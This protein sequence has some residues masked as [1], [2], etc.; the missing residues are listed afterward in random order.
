MQID[1]NPLAYFKELHL[2]PRAIFAIGGVFFFSGLVGRNVELI[3][4][5]IGLIFVA[6]A[7]NL[8]LNAF[9][10]HP[11]DGRLQFWWGG[12]AQAIP[13]ILVGL[14]CIYLAAYMYRHGSLPPYFQRA[15]P[16]KPNN[17]P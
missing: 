8:V 14:L 3:L 7:W 1:L 17:S 11:Y 15:L 9:W 6:L 5:G 4:F 13:I 12:L 16:A 10:S 2:V